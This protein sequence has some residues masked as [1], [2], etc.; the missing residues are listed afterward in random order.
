VDHMPY[1]FLGKM[2][3]ASSQLLPCSEEKLA[4]FSQDQPDN[5]LANYYYAIALQKAGGDS[6]KAT[7]ASRVE[8]L[9]KKSIEIDPKFSE[10]YL[11]LGI[12]YADRGELGKAIAAY[13]NA[14]AANP[15]LA[16]AHFRLGQAYKK[17]GE[18][19]KASR[20]FQAHHRIQQKEAF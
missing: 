18:P 14:I 12:V 9:L 15:N 1:I 5:A 13:R 2:T 6:D 16:E 17:I 3:L 8:T 20:E 19:L 10:A 7:A 4:R 11:Q